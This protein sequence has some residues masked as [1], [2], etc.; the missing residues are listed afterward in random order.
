[1]QSLTK[2]YPYFSQAYYYMGM[3]R[4]KQKDFQIAAL[5]FEKALRIYPNYQKAKKALN[6]VK[7]RLPN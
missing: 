4:Y 7:K 2:K 3:T 6:N 1:M 5:L